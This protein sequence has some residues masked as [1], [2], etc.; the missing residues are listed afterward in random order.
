[1]W[2]CIGVQGKDLNLDS[3]MHMLAKIQHQGLED[4]SEADG[5]PGAI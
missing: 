3:Q 4:H 1:M 5:E 2:C